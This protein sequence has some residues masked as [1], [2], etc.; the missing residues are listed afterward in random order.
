MEKKTSTHLWLNFWKIGRTLR[1]M[2]KRGNS[3]NWLSKGVKLGL[4]MHHKRVNLSQARDGKCLDMLW[5]HFL[6]GWRWDRRY[7]ESR[8][9]EVLSL[10]GG[11]AGGFLGAFFVS[12][13][14]GTPALQLRQHAADTQ[15]RISST[16]IVFCLFLQIF[17]LKVDLEVNHGGLGKEFD[18]M[19]QYMAQMCPKQC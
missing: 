15:K 2:V 6:P 18:P 12:L 16:V 17:A 9:N 19:S 5:N 3:W 1:L 13:A 7:S 10:S 14:G 8:V 4:C 11:L